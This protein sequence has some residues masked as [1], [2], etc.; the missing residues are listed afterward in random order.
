MSNVVL[1]HRAQGYNL[2]PHPFV[3][4]VVVS[5]LFGL[6]FKEKKKKA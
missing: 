1:I 5:E 4:V 2:P 6:F 3:F